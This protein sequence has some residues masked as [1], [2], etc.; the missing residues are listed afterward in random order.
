MRFIKM[1]GMMSSADLE[2]CSQLGIDA[3]GVVVEFPQPVPWN[4]SRYAAQ[5][6][7]ASAPAALHIV[8]V[9]SGSPVWIEAL[10]G[11]VRPHTVQVHGDET[12]A[13]VAE[14]VRRLSLLGIDVFRALRIDPKTGEA[15]GEVADPVTAAKRLAETGVRAIVVDSK[16]PDRP[17]G[18]GVPVDVEAIRSIVDAVDVPVIAAG[19]LQPENVAAVA[20]QTGAWGVDVLTGIERAPGVKDRGRM[21]AFAAAVRRVA[22][23]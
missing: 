5:E 21:E 11:F 19:G 18:T 10:A 13:D 14:L 16:V 12:L 6:M 8:M 1:C 3:A 4:L 20:E 7:V 22:V 23:R 9:S 2:I 17:G 15:A